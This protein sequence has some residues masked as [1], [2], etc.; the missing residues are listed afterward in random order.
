MNKD[1]NYWFKRRRYGYGWVP[2]TWQGWTV[3]AVWLA[4]VIA[5]TIWVSDIPKNTFQAE[6][7][8]FLLFVGASTAVLVFLSYKKGP[9][10]KWRWGKSKQDSPEEDW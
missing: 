7:V 8:Y 4:G 1:K 2:V 9:S 3:L 6:V 10:P 5:A